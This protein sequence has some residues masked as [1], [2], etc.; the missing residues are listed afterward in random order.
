MIRGA[1]EVADENRVSGWVYCG[2]KSLRNE[3]VLAFV[4][5]HCVG[6]GR[7]DLFRQDLLDAKLGDGYCGFDFPVHLSEPGQAEQMIVRLQFSDAALL[8]SGCRIS[9]PRRLEPVAMDS[10]PNLGAI[11][12]A[13]V[14]WMLDRGML[15]QPESDFLKAMHTIGAYKRVLRQP[16]RSAAVEPPRVEPEPLVQ[17]LIALFHLSDVRL[18]RTNV[19]SISDINTHAD[20]LRRSASPVIALWSRDI[21]R[22]SLEERSHLGGRRDGL[23]ISSSPVPGGIDYSFGPDSLLFVHRDCSFAPRGPAPATGILLL[24]AA[25]AEKESLARPVP[26]EARFSQ[27]RAA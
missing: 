20:L 2:E 21:C 25:P 5:S 7:V 24:A 13:S 10:R 9:G 1:I 26:A 3:T 11:D 6:A 22:I 17:D 27:V 12:P 18:V 16:K 19:A 14:L 4:G 23:A 8:Q 15:D